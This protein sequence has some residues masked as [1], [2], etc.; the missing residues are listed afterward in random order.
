MLRT[1]SV[2]VCYRDSLLFHRCA[3]RS[4]AGEIY[5]AKW[6]F[7]QPVQAS[8]ARAI[9]EDMTRVVAALGSRFTSAKP[10]GVPALPVSTAGPIYPAMNPLAGCPPVAP[11][12]FAS[13]ITASISDHR[14][15]F[16]PE[17][18][19]GHPANLVIAKH[20]NSQHNF[21]RQTGFN[22]RSHWH[23]LSM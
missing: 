11:K 15:A 8:A 2:P 6:R 14:Q 13:G 12:H 22:H 21:L 19:R 17:V 16:F 5:A 4:H 18:F 7:G 3:F 9:F 1:Q 20:R 23:Q 10:L